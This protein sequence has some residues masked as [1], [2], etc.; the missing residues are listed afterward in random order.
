MTFLLGNLVGEEFW[1]CYIDASMSCD[2]RQS[3]LS[4]GFGFKCNCLRCLAGDMIFTSD[5]M[6]L[7][8]EQLRILGL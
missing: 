3:L 4:Q 6:G 8:H 5:I 1:I 7:G 2:A